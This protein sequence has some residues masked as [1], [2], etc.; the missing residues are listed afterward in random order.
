M[1]C[2]AMDYS[3]SCHSALYVSGN[4]QDGPLKIEIA[5]DKSLP[6]EQGLSIR[7]FDLTPAGNSKK[8]SARGTRAVIWQMPTHYT[9]KDF[10]DPATGRVL[11]ANAW[12][13]DYVYRGGSRNV[14]SI[15]TCNTFLQRLIEGQLGG[16]LNFRA[17][18][19]FRRSTLHHEQFIRP[20]FEHP[21]LQF[22]YET[23][24]PGSGPNDVILFKVNVN[25]VCR[26]GKSKR[27]GSCI[28][29]VS[30]A[31]D[32]SPLKVEN[33]PRAMNSP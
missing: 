17:S 30:K 27:G 6:P 29:Q 15:N 12:G 1:G 9:N 3:N 20:G 7:V 19:F 24:T 25:S 16:R 8:F 28:A 21:I 14:G 18:E 31:D 32:G 13:Q 26:D 11:V 4:D 23:S 22:K 33:F 10:M 5:D 2:Q